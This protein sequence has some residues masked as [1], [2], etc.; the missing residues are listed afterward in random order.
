ML[1]FL[2]VLHFQQ[3]AGA[4][5]EALAAKATEHLNLATMTA[6]NLRQL[7]DRAQAIHPAPGMSSNASRRFPAI[8]NAC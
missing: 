5:Q 7:V 1:I 3:K 4:H 2:W 8:G 6:E